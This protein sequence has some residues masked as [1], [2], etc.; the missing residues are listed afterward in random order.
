M[1]LLGWGIQTCFTDSKKQGIWHNVL[2]VLNFTAEI[3]DSFP[4]LKVRAA[5]PR[6]FVHCF[7]LKT[8]RQERNQ[9]CLR[10]FRKGQIRPLCME[11]NYA[12]HFKSYDTCCNFSAT[13]R[14]PRYLPW[15]GSPR[16]LPQE[17][18]MMRNKLQQFIVHSLKAIRMRLN[19]LFHD[20]LPG[21]VQR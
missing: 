14:T 4:P 5:A 11:A 1:L 9:T 3:Q 18:A 6:K 10:I 19:V 8:R 7:V 16:Y 20:H 21:R 2:T 13:E 12:K 15:N 17:T